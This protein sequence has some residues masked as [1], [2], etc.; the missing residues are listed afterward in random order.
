MHRLCRGSLVMAIIWGTGLTVAVALVGLPAL[1][2]YQEWRQLQVTTEPVLLTCLVAGA[3]LDRAFVPDRAGGGESQI[4]LRLHGRQRLVQ[5]LS[6]LKGAV[7]I[8]SPDQALEFARLRTGPALADGWVDGPQMAEIVRVDRPYR[9]VTDDLGGSRLAWLGYHP[10]AM[11][12]T[13]GLLH[14]KAFKAGRFTEARAHPVSGGYVVERWVLVGVGAD[15]YRVQLVREHVG[16]DG[17]CSREVVKDRAAPRLPG[18]QFTFPP[19][20]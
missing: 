7:A 20:C 4:R 13:C 19:G 17:A 9:R 14:P 6:E 12:G 15:K 3:S 16:L 18:S 5:T 10:G 1:L 2:V 8:A 11:S